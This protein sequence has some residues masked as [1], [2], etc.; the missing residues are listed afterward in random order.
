MPTNITDPRLQI[1]DLLRTNW[2]NSQMLMNLSDDE[3][4]TG[5]FDANRDFPQVTVTDTEE[6]VVN[7]GESGVTGL[8]G[9]GTGVTQHRNGTV[10]INC[11]AGSHDAYS[12]R[13]EEQVQAKAMADEVERIVFHNVASITGLKS[14]SVTA[15]EKLV[16]TDAEPAEHR[17][18][19][20]VTYNWHR[21]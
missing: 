17:V 15:R 12:A 5:W 7:G 19:L 10:T 8:K 18:M 20:E 16:N 14:I 4:H 9:D 11:W 13:G 2:D 1:R 3:I 21:N 6:G